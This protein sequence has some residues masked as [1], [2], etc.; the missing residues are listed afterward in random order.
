MN[1][2]LILTPASPLSLRTIRVC[3][4]GWGAKATH[5][6]LLFPA[7]P[8]SCHRSRTI[9][10]CHRSFFPNNQYSFCH[11]LDEEQ[12]TAT[13]HRPIFTL[14]PKLD[15]DS[16]APSSLTPTMTGPPGSLNFTSFLPTSLVLSVGWP[17]W[18]WVGGIGRDKGLNVNRALGEKGGRYFV[19]RYP[20]LRTTEGP[21]LYGRKA[22]AIRK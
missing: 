18:G 3:G 2:D 13:G 9:N 20:M 22:W 6:E 19:C 7:H 10:S 16:L 12:Y 14:Q 4:V 15:R 1:K 8:Y 17:V 11:Y 21:T 5:P